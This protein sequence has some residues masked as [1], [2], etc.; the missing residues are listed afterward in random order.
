MTN[1]YKPTNAPLRQTPLPASA[2]RRRL[3]YS[4]WWAVGAG[5]VAGILMRL[6]FWGSTGD[7]YSAMLGSF[8]LGSPLVVGVVTVYVAELEERR[9]WRYYF[10]APVI[11]TTLYVVGTLALL[12]EGWIC[13]ILIIP[14]FAFVAGLAGLLTGLICR[15]TNWPRR[16]FVSCIAVLPLL[17]GAVEHKAPLPQRERVQVRE[18]FVPVP[19][20]ALWRELVDTRD[21]R[22]GEFESAWIHR[23]GVPPTLAGNGE[24]RAGEYLRHVTMGRGVKFDQVA[25]EWRENELVKWRY[26][27]NANSFPPG[28][29]DDH[30]RIGGEHFDLAETTY[31]LHPQGAGTRVVVRVSYRVSTHFN[32]YAGPLADFLVGDFCEEA[33]AFYA[34]RAATRPQAS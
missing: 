20:S 30:V 33:L 15:V 19:P 4:G 32:W 25:E 21:I 18:L 34:R 8:I 13:A 17:G 2:L 16:A 22:R 28:A 12:I 23:I 31:E 7:A 14:L 6:V 9:T 11:A 5:A 24:L 10:L 26:R 1:P 3:P 29:L 27:F